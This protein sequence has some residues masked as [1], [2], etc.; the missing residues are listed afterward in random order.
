MSKDECNRCRHCGIVLP[1]RQGRG[2]QKQYCSDRC[3]LSSNPSKLV[4]EWC[5]TE[6]NARLGHRPRSS[7]FC[8]LGCAAAYGNYLRNGHG[9]CSPLSITECKSCGKPFVRHHGAVAYCSDECRPRA[10]Y[11]PKH[12]EER[13]CRSCGASFIAEYTGGQI[14]AYC[15]DECRKA[16]PKTR[17][18]ERLKSDKA[19][20]ERYRASKRARKLQLPAGTMAAF[21]AKVVANKRRCWWCG[22]K[23]TEVTI[24]HAIPR[25]KGGTNSVDNLVP[26]CR[27][28]N[29][30]SKHAKLPNTEWFPERKRQLT[31]AVW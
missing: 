23:M 19:Y 20:R 29:C 6:Y 3:R 14:S 17:H 24:D 12:G 9:S 15:S 18:A 27:E 10:A 5:G 11:T 7:K 22:R 21:N 8:S 16:A 31:I 28:C 2:P 30:G 25:S 26:A 1:H 4:C 13:E